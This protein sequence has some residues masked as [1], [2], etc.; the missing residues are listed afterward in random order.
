MMASLELLP[1]RRLREEKASR[2]VVRSRH[3]LEE[4]NRQRDNHNQRLLDYGQWRRQKEDDMFESIRNGKLKPADLDRFKQRIQ[5]L[6]AQQQQLELD[7]EH[8]QQAV[9]EAALTHEQRRQDLR[10][11]HK[12]LE[13][14]ECLYQDQLEEQAHYEA[15]RAERE[16]EDVIIRPVECFDDFI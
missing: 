2:E 1:L 5:K 7:L 12:A 14:I 11:A 16:L 8:K 3:S 4:A 10:G 13:K 9:D 15:V 6:R